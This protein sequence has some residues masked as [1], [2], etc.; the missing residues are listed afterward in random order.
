MLQ[1][2]TKFCCKKEQGSFQGY[3]VIAVRCNTSTARYYVRVL[4]SHINRYWS[5]DSGSTQAPQVRSPPPET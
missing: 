1:F 5:T 3:E 2:M 4:T